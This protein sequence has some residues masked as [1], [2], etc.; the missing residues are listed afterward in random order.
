MQGITRLG[1]IGIFLLTT[2]AFSFSQDVDNSAL[3]DESMLDK[4]H[5]IYFGWAEDH[6]KAVSLMGGAVYP[7]RPHLPKRDDHSW[8]HSRMPWHKNS[9][10]IVMFMLSV[11]NSTPYYPNENNIFRRKIIDWSIA[12]NYLPFPVSQWEKDH[13]KVRITHPVSLP[14]EE[15]INLWKASMPNMWN[16]TVKTPEDYEQRG[17]GGNVYGFYQYDR[18]FDHDVPDMVIQY[19]LEGYWDVARQIM[20]GATFKRLSEGLLQKEK[21][22]DAIPKY[23]IALAQYLQTSRDRDYFSEELFRETRNCAYAVH[24]MRKEQLKPDLTEPRAYMD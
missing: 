5:W 13:I 4:R 20:E 15:L 2:S 8:D 14:Y 17:S 16:A 23:L 7:R 3:I 12:E 11:D 6:P 1:V 18:V 21:Y 19:I 10:D 22:N 9:S 24:D